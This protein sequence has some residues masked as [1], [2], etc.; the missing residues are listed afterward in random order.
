[1]IISTKYTLL[2]TIKVFRDG[3]PLKLQ[4]QGFILKLIDCYSS[5]CFIITLNIV[6]IIH[7]K[8]RKKYLFLRIKQSFHAKIIYKNL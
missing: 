1:M 2:V 4:K 7:N 8:N 3:C 5:V 6:C